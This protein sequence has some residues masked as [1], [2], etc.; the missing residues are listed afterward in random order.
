MASLSYPEFQA[1]EKCRLCR[2]LSF[3]EIQELLKS[4]RLTV[5]DISAD[6]LAAFRGDR[7]D[8]LWII[9]EGR[10]AA[11]IG[12]ISG[13]TILVE[14]LKG[15]DVVAG[16]ILFAE[17]NLLPVQLRAL[18]RT[19]ILILSRTNLLHIFQRDPRILENFL[20]EI[21]DKINF[22][23]DKIRMLQFST[24]RQ[25][26]AGFYLDLWRRQATLNVE[27]PY[28]IELMAEVFGVARPALSRCL[29]ELV[30]EG[31]LQ[32]GGRAYA[33]TDPERLEEVLRDD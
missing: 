21:G 28:T 3:K 25:K 16:G 12:D 9:L 6:S 19:R 15:G 5:K 23:A 7:Y 10:L 31:C 22:L 33:L 14:T 2:G 18:S 13:K 24:I 32:R 27:N 29:S 20:G 30:E 1:L 17:Q 11:E 4:L 8:H 26:I